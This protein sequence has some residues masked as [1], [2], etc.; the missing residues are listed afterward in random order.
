MKIKTLSRIFAGALTALAVSGA[1][2]QSKPTELKVGITTFLSGPASVFGVP[3]M[4]AADLYIEQLNA[5]GGINGVK[6]VPTYIDEGVGADKLLSEYR[7][8]V[9]ETGT[10]VMLSAVSSGNCNIVAPVA[11]DLKVLNILWDCGTEKVLEEKRYRYV[12]RTQANA[13]IEMLSTVLYL[14]K[15][16]PDIKTIA[17]MNQDYA[18][19][20]DSWE[21]FRNALLAL[22]PDVKIVAE[23]FP[24]FG[25]TDYSTEISRLQALHP[26]VILS[27]AWGGDL[28]TFVRQA[29]QRGLMKSS[30]LVLPLAESSLERLGNALPDG[31]IVGARGDHYFL[32]PQYKD[33]PKLK[34]FTKKFQEKT[35]AYPIY[36]VFHMVQALDGL[37]AGYQKAIKANK[38]QWPST[39]Q[40]AD[41]MRGLEFRGLTGTV[42]IR[43]D[44]QGLEDQ[45]LGVTRKVPGYNFPVLEKIMIYP[46]DLISTP[47]GQKS[48]EW[49]KTIKPEL[50]KNPRFKQLN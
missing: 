28:D 46:A 47:V 36:P 27:T 31:V 9:Q 49:V 21:L 41:A 13:T 45:L 25:A 14:L 34:N 20:R 16:K 1:L 44:G 50:L 5:A 40:V 17:V 38:G 48:P 43:E 24:K 3:G 29:S 22:K 32:H 6:I 33:E 26:D 18:W 2:A 42:K 4:A 15:T 30:L 8:V 39:E 37:V 19:G 35:G 11:E 12:T 10:K 23:L 7:R